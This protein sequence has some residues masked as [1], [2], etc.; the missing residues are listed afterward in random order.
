M[1][2]MRSQTILSAIIVE[3]HLLSYSC[4]V[5]I[6]TP[7]GQVPVLFI[8]DKPLSGSQAIARYLAEKHGMAEET[9]IIIPLKYSFQYMLSFS[10][11]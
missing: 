1:C 10:D 6:A 4:F 2:T 9:S 7:F 8:D 11:S 3:G 5:I